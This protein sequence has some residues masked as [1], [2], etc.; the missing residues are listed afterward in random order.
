VGEYAVIARTQEIAADVNDV[1]QRNFTTRTAGE[2]YGGP[3][4]SPRDDS[5]VNRH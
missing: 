1:K 5:S 4:R 2:V 3:Y